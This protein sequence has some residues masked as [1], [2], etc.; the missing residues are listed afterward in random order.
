MT[1]TREIP[2]HSTFVFGVNGVL[3]TIPA[4]YRE[5]GITYAGDGIEL[6]SYWNIPY[7]V[8]NSCNIILTGPKAF[9]YVTYKVCESGNHNVHMLHELW[10]RQVD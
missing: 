7:I 6:T 4:I 5:G 3:G 2:S 1:T 8:R 9:Q 10:R